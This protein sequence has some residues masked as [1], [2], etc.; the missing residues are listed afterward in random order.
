M[1]PASHCS[2][3]IRHSMYLVARQASPICAL[4]SHGAWFFILSQQCLRLAGADAFSAK[5]HSPRLKST[6]G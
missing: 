5:V 6:V 1:A 3:Q 2:P 4:I